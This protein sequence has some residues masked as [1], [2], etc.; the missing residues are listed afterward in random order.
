MY[1]RSIQLES[2][3]IHRSLNLS[4]FNLEKTL[5]E[6][7]FKFSYP[8]KDLEQNLN[9]RRLELIDK[10][11]NYSNQPIQ[12]LQFAIQTVEDTRKLILLQVKP[13]S[14]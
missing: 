8:I 1:N 5:L 3:Q 13:T 7:K 2:L 12:E 4:K 9:E 14:A 10:F 6:A 11:K